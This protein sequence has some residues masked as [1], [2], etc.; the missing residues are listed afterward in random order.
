MPDSSL[1]AIALLLCVAGFS[2]FALAMEVHWQQVRGGSFPGR[3]TRSLLRWLGAAAVATSLLLCLRVDHASMASLVWVMMMAASALGV[4]FTLTWCP[5]WLAP[6]VI[7]IR[8][9]SRTH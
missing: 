9:A 2:W 8:P 5:R 7:F 6:F 4:A 1:L 3:G